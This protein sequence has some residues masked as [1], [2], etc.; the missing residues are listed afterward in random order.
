M[1]LAFTDRSGNRRLPFEFFCSRETG[2]NYPLFPSLTQHP[3][4]TLHSSHRA[5]RLLVG[6]SGNCLP[7]TALGPALHPARRSAADCQIPRIELS[8]RPV[9][10]Q[11]A[12]RSPSIRVTALV[13]RAH[14]AN[15]EPSARPCFGCGNLRVATRRWPIEGLRPAG[16]VQNQQKPSRVASADRYR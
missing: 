2:I 16:H 7:V 5:F 13:A 14:P 9:V 10:A 11:P 15:H 6:S 12:E 3:T 8:G 1:C 4:I